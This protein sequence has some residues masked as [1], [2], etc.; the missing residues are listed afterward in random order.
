MD[1]VVF[2]SW[3]SDLPNATNRSFIEKALEDAVKAIRSDDSVKVE[4]VIDRDTS[5]VPGSPDI[6]TTIFAKIDQCQ[7]FVCDVS[8]INPGATS[9]LTPNPNVLLELGYALKTLGSRR[10]IMVMNT[11]FGTPELLPF[12]LRMRRVIPYNSP[13]IATERAAERKELARK[14]ESQIRPI[15]DEVSAVSNQPEISLSKQAID[16]IQLGLPNAASLTKRFMDEF[17]QKLEAIAPVFSNNE[18]RDEVLIQSLDNSVA[19]VIE[20]ARVIEAIALNNSQQSASAIFA[21]F[22]RLVEH[23]NP[24]IGFSGSFNDVDFDFYK[25]I[26]HELFVILFTFFINEERWEIIEELLNEGLYIRNGR[27]GNPRT[28][29][30]DA[31]SEHVKLLE[32]RNSR[33]ELKRT[34][35]HADLLNSRHTQGELGRLVPMQNFI[36][37][38]YFLFLRSELPKPEAPRHDYPRIDWRPWSLLYMKQVPRYLTRAIQTKHA[39]ILVKPLGLQDVETFRDRFTQRGSLAG[40][41]FQQ[42]SSGYRLPHFDGTLIASK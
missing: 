24:A 13:E 38:D 40:R 26:G 15:I 9:R 36:D 12:D 4:P 10:I 8:I 3:Q 37:A 6:S 32:I 35:V 41:M 19:L 1:F 11:A 27:D 30:F 33:L 7:V 28:E 14:I 21:G 18:E 5:G 42:R 25:F 2:Y 17:I 31:I 16:A 20:Y 39:Q 22:E 34:S 29:N 23:Y